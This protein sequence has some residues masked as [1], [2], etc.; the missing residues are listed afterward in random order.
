M[1]LLSKS[2]EKTLLPLYATEA[3]PLEDKD[4]QVKFDEST[5][6]GHWRSST[7]PAWLSKLT[8]YSMLMLRFRRLHARSMALFATSIASGTR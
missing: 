2:I 7:S 3:C 4:V 1:K 5:G 8:S 6:H